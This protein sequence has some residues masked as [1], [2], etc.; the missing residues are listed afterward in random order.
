MLVWPV[1]TE[2]SEVATA[3]AV[4]QEAISYIRR[5]LRKLKTLERTEND[6]NFDIDKSVSSLTQRLAQLSGE[7]RRLEDREEQ[8]YAN[9]GIEGR[10]ELMA[11][12]FFG[13]LPEEYQ[14]RLLKRMREIFSEQNTPLQI[15]KT[16]E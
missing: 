6:H 15:G 7:V 8:Q 5:R 12:E 11:T 2:E 14:V 3:Q 1:V 9:L 16:R 13:A 4:T 10:M